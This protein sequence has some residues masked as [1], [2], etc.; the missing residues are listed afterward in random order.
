M[1]FSV[2]TTLS[3]DSVMIDVMGTG[4]VVMLVSTIVFVRVTGTV[5][6]VDALVMTVDVTGQVVVLLNR[7]RIF[8]L[9]MESLIAL[10]STLTLCTLCS[11]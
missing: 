9:L 2:E 5:E 6:V 10:E 4:I 7:F 1:S 11:L 3:T 8:E